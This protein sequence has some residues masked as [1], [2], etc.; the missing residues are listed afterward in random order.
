V[1]TAEEAFEFI[2]VTKDK[3]DVSELSPE[4]VLVPKEHLLIENI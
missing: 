3:E 2:K 4:R 1:E